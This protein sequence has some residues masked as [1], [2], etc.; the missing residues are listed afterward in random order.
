[1]KIKQKATMGATK[2]KWSFFFCY[3]KILR[4]VILKKVRPTSKK[5]TPETHSVRNFETVSRRRIVKS[6]CREAGEKNLEQRGDF[7]NAT[8][9]FWTNWARFLGV[10]RMGLLEWRWELYAVAVSRL[11]SPSPPWTR[12]LTIGLISPQHPLSDAINSDII[13]INV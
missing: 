1:M 4:K 12:Q 6:F 2:K 7:L 8:T 9:N 13:Q 11:S 5:P 10:D 3:W